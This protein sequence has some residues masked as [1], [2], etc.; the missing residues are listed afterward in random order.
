MYKI[1]HTEL[2]DNILLFIFA[3]NQKSIKNEKFI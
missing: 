1:V 2:N 3:F